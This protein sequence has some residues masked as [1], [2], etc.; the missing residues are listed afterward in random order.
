MDPA[1]QLFGYELPFPREDL[2]VALVAVLAFI[3]AVVVLNALGHGLMNVL[4]LGRPKA[5]AQ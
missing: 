5:K 2:V 4:G 1:R 3:P